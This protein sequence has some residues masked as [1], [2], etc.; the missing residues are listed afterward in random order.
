MRP[1]DLRIAATAAEITTGVT[2]G[3]STLIQL[4]GIGDLF[5]GKISPTSAT[6]ADS[7]PLQRLHPTLAP[8]PSRCLR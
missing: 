3:G 6:S 8:R 5:A 2:P 1:L 4:H 7:T